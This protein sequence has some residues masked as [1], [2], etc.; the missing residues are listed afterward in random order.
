MTLNFY[1]NVELF[2]PELEEDALAKF[3]Q[4]HVAWPAEPQEQKEARP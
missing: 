1:E 4:S 3:V 2:E